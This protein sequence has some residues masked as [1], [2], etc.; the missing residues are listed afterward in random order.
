MTMRRSSRLSSTVL[1]ALGATTTLSLS[2]CGGGDPPAA[3]PPLP[4]VTYS[5]GGTVSGLNGTLVLLNGSDQ[6]SVAANGTFVFPTAIASGASYNVTV[7]TQPVGQTCVVNAGSGTVSANVTNVSVSCTPTPAVAA[8]GPRRIALSGENDWALLVKAD[9]TVLAL[10]SFMP[11]GAGSPVAGT[12]ATLV[13]GVDGVST[14]SAHSPHLSAATRSN[15]S[16]VYWGAVPLD[17][18]GG[19]FVT[20]PAESLFPVPTVST[21]LDDVAETRVLYAGRMLALKKDGSLWVAPGRRETATGMVTAVQIAAPGEVLSVAGNGAEH[22]GSDVLPVVGAAG[23]VRLLEIEFSWRNSGPGPVYDRELDY[24][25]T[26]VTG[27]PPVRQA[28]CSGSNRYLDLFCLALTPDGAVWSWGSASD[29]QLIPAQIAGLGGVIAIA[30]SRFN[31]YALTAG[32]N[33]YSW[34]R[35]SM[36]GRETSDPFGFQS[37]PALVPQLSGVVEI[38]TPY[39]DSDSMGQVLVRK[40]DGTVW[41]W[42]VNRGGILGDGT[43]TNRTTP[44]QALGINLN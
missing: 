36:L 5:L 41:G 15:G 30:T 9:G 22:G 1:T 34:G 8:A 18:G 3:N 23:D 24:S 38:A 11:G 17:T 40:S 21:L 26:A 16:V 35:N 10:G 20:D 27:L 12:T 14:V 25:Y 13:P 19:S 33:V 6:V 28:A 31:R 39:V 7:G 42:G 4:A 32:G 43:T 2:A 44:V 37:E 29:T